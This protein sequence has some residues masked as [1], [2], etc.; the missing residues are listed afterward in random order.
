VVVDAVRDGEFLDGERL[1]ASYGGVRQQ[2]KQRGPGRYEAVLP[3]Q[4]QGGQIAVFRERELIARRSAS[5]PPASLEPAGAQER[6][7]ELARLTGGGMLATLNDYRPPEG[8]EPLPLWPLAALLALLV[9]LVELVV[10]RLA[11]LQGR[12]AALLSGGRALQQ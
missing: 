4:P 7:Q 9:F 10:R 1:E 8:R 2:L 5:F 3:V 6:L 12:P 11:P